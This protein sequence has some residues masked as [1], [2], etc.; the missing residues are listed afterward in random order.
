MGQPEILVIGNVS[1]DLIMGPQQPWPITG[2]EV[3]L[4]HSELR[5]GGAAGNV[6][7]ALQALA[8][9]STLVT[10][11][12]NDVMGAWLKS[13]FEHVPTRWTLTESATSITVGITHPDGERTFFTH[14]GHL[15]HLQLQQ[16]LEAFARI[17]KGDIVVLMG[18]FLTPTLRRE[19]PMLLETA[20]ILGASVV[21]DPGWPPE[22]WTQTVRA[23]VRGWLS[24]C[25]HLL[26]NE[27]E[28]FGLS[29]CEDLNTAADVIRA[30]LPVDATLVIKCGPR[31]A[32]VWHGNDTQHVSAP[33]VNVVDT[34]GAGDT[35][36]AGYLS[37]VVV[38]DAV[39]VCVRKG[40]E[41]ASLAI[42]TNPRQYRLP[43]M[44]HAS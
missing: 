32:H 24:T 22:G 31:G 40:I 28:A 27:V 21:L 10:N 18:S 14:L 36:N 7:L 20:R 19:Y 26:I 2:T 17:K 38:G 13:A 29:A 41:T 9:S 42:S 3:I 23:E 12:G 4:E 39:A 16:I 15:E 5:A 11:V 30:S 33:T 6:A 8:V 43:K 1:V 35:F 37:G 44:E 25:Q 34:I